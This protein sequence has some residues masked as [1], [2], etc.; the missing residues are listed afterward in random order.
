MTFSTTKVGLT[1]II[2]YIVFCDM[3]FT[4]IR[5]WSCLRSVVIDEKYKRYNFM[6]E[7]G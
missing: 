5:I 7:D 6:L 1:P 2:T 4:T 3:R